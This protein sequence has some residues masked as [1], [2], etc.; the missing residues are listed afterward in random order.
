MVVQVHTGSDQGTTIVIQHPLPGGR[1][2]NGVM[3]HAGDAVFV[4][5]GD[6][7]TAGQLVSTIGL[8]FSLQNGGRFAHL[9]Y[10]LYPGPFDPRHQYAYRPVSAGLAGWID[11]SEF[12]PAW[13]DRTQPLVPGLRAPSAAL[14]GVVAKAAA[15]EIGKAYAEALR[16]REAVERDSDAW[17]DADEVLQA[18]KDAPRNALRRAQALVEGGYP[19][20]AKDLLEGFVRQ[21]GSLPGIERVRE[22]LEEWAQDDS[23]QLALKGQPKVAAAEE[24]SLKERDEARRRALWADL[25]EKYG[26][27]CL[28][29]R[30]RE[31]TDR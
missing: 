17:K 13:R 16:A 6:R 31:Q 12:L 18:L 5:A 26:D 9:H 7:V 15:G 27:T 4:R 19:V 8:S 11:P 14:D 23:F 30:I 21:A 22:T 2:V 20:E 24:K 25:L 10:A 29:E 28:G 1:L 3:M